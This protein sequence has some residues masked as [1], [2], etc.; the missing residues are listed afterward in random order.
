MMVALKACCDR[1]EDLKPV[2]EML[3][4]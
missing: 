4:E 3:G 1:I 2:G